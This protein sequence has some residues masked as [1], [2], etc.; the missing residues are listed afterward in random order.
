MIGWS[1]LLAGSVR[2]PL[3]GRD[4]LVGVLVAIGDGLMLGLHTLARRWSG[5][6]P[7]F[8]V[9]A[10]SNPCGWHHRLERPATRRALCAL[11]DHRLGDEHPALERDDADLSLLF[12]LFVLLRRRSLAIAAMILVL[13]VTV[14][15]RPYGWL[16][17]NARPITSLRRSPTSRC[18]RR[19][20]GELCWR[21]SGSACSRCWSRSC[22]RA[23]DAAADRHR[24]VR[25]YASSSRLIVLTLIAWPLTA[26][27]P[28]WPADPCLAAS[29]EGTS[30]RARLIRETSRFPQAQIA[31]RGVTVASGGD[32]DQQES[33]GMVRSLVRLRPLSQAVRASE[34]RG[35]GALS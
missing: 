33:I 18:S 13:T 19:P 5:R 15:P 23:A 32:R 21:P 20:D 34:R 12:V 29:F 27:T 4:V 9:G 24:L 28:R 26:G 7:S 2:D 10:S 35:S 25:P 31:S 22:E 30:R 14:R 8:P 11:A 6:P 3:V 17:A 16:L 1:R